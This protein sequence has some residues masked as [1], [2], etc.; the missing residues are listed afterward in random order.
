MLETARLQHPREYRTL[1]SAHTLYLGL[2]ASRPPFSDRR[3]R[4]AMAHAL[5]RE[6]LTDTLWRGIIAPAM[7]GLV[8]PGIPGHSPGIGLGYDPDRARRLLAEA[9]YPRGEGF[10]TVEAVAHWS[11]SDLPVAQYLQAQWRDVLGL[12]I[13]WERLEWLAYKERLVARPPQLWVM[14]WVADYPNPDCFLRVAMHLPYVLWANERYEQLLES[15]RRIADD[16]DQIK[17]YRAA[18]RL[19]VEDAPIIPLTHGRQHYLV[20]PWVRRYPVSAI[21]TSYWKDVIIEPH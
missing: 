19:L 6:M 9:G 12:E 15:A 21:R 18:D 17:F 13:T 3:V 11:A 2:D 1:P 8:P 5:D 10:P 14:G 20:K 7:G 16:A 4:Q